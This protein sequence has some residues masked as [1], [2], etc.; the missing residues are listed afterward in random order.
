MIRSLR[1]HPTM[2]LGGALL[3]LVVLVAV[4]APL[5]ATA[6]PA[7]L[8]PA[9]RVR[10]PSAEAFFGTDMLGRDIFSRCVYGA[11]VS[12]IVGLGVAV[13]ASA[14]GMV[15]GLIAGF[16]RWADGV[17]MRVMD[18]MMSIAIVLAIALMT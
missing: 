5:I 2:W 17:I 13:L 10:A 6:D 9:L 4:F 11:R 16:T 8:N 18:G 14:V 7:A 3:V 12:L 15:I 1:R